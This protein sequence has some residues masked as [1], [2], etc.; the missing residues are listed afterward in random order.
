MGAFGTTHCEVLAREPE[1][2]L[3]ISWKNPPLDT[4]VTWRLA[5]AGSGTRLHFEHAGFDL[6]DPRQRRAYEGMSSGWRA[7][8]LTRLAEVLAPI[9]RPSGS[10]ARPTA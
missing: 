10:D 3:R 4:T 8:I 2:L 7:K 9:S 1:R 6:A 5:P